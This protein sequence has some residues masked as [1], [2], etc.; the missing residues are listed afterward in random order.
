MTPAA[1]HHDSADAANFD[2]AWVFVLILLVGALAL[3]WLYFRAHRDLD[4]LDE[5]LATMTGDLAQARERVTQLEDALTG[6]EKE[7]AQWKN[8]CWEK[9]TAVQQALL[10]C[11]SL[12]RRVAED[13]AIKLA[14]EQVTPARASQPRRERAPL[15]PGELAAW[16][17]LKAHWG[18]TADG[19]A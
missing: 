4:E 11:D 13:E 17:D 14:N 6:A 12:A 15:K 9:E 8:L 7:L 16:K 10:R 19:A 1:Y 2:V 18:D 5:Q 3:T